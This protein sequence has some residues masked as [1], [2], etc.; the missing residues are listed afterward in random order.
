MEIRCFS[1]VLCVGLAFLML[2]PGAALGGLY[3]SE[4]KTDS[5]G[6]WTIALYVDA[7]CNLEMYWEDPSLPYLLNIPENDGLNIVAIIDWLSVE[8]VEMV[9]ISGGESTVVKTYDEMNFGAGETFQWFLTE[10]DTYYPADHLVVIPWD[11][12]SAWKG[13]CWDDSSDGDHITLQEMEAAI[14]GAGVYIDILAFDACS[15]S[16]IEMAYSAARTGLVELLV[17]SE[18][19]VAGDGFPYDLMF[20]PV[21]LD[22]SRTPDQVAVDMV[23]GWIASYE[24]LP[25][26]WYC[27]LGVVDV[28]EI[29]DS[30]EVISDWVVQMT[31]GMPAYGYNYRMALRD[32]Y[33]VSCGS[34]YQV[35]MVDLGRHLLA[36]KALKDDAELM[37]TTQAMVDLIDGAVKY[38][39]NTDTTEACGGI[40]IYWGSHNDVWRTSMDA[41]C[42]VPF[43]D[44]SG[45]ADF[46]V[47]YNMLTCGWMRI[48]K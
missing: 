38:V 11:H 8:G 42:D 6:T 17:A 24:P 13:F 32:S 18:E 3:N 33:Y 25:W 34:H 27:T 10:V 30:L 2:A 35:D 16:S 21:A 9:E 31:E 41:Y 15:C 43:A 47:L 4:A 12:G 45:W 5:E 26:A 7:D 19:L 36:D 28:M 48:S 20:T 14:V 29:A 37:A 40:S 39:Y 46:V 23:D 44:E 22:P 1:Y